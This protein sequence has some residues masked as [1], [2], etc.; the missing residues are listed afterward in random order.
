MKKLL[1]ILFSLF[2]LFHEL[3][4]SLPA[5]AKQDAKQLAQPQAQSQPA[6]K[7]GNAQLAKIKLGLAISQ[8]NLDQIQEIE[9]TFPVVLSQPL[10]NN[11]IPV[12]MLIDEILEGYDVLDDEVLNKKIDIYKFFLEKKIYPTKEKL[13]K[14]LDTLYDTKN[15][16]HVVIFYEN[17][18]LNEAMEVEAIPV[19]QDMVDLGFVFIN[20][21]I[22]QSQKLKN[23]YYNNVIESKT[24]QNIIERIYQLNLYFYTI[25]TELQDFLKGKTVRQKLITSLNFFNYLQKEYLAIEATS[26]NNLLNNYFMIVGE[27]RTYV[28]N[29]GTLLFTFKNV[30]IVLLKDGLKILIDQ[31]YNINSLSFSGYHFVI[32]MFNTFTKDVN[33]IITKLNIMLENNFNPDYSDGYQN[34]LLYFILS[35]FKHGHLQKEDILQI[36]NILFSPNSTHKPYSDINQYILI[37]N[38]HVTLLSEAMSENLDTE[39]IQFLLNKGAD[40][41]QIIILGGNNVSNSM[42]IFF[43]D[44]IIPY[45][46]IIMNWF[47]KNGKLNRKYEIITEN[48]G[49]YFKVNLTWLQY[50]IGQKN[51]F[52]D[53]S[54]NPA[55]SKRSI[56]DIFLEKYGQKFNKFDNYETFDLNIN[57]ILNV[58]L[59]ATL[60]ELLQLYKGD[61]NRLKELCKILHKYDLLAFDQSIAQNLLD[62]NVPKFFEKMKNILNTFP[63]SVQDKAYI[64]QSIDHYKKYIEGTK[65]LVTTEAET[66]AKLEQEQQHSMEQKEKEFED[67]LER[68]AK[69][70]E[71]AAYRL[72]KLEKSAEPSKQRIA[73]EEFQKLSQLYQSFEAKKHNIEAKLQPKIIQIVSTTSSSAAQLVQPKSL[74]DKIM[75]QHQA[76]EGATPNDVIDE[77]NK[78]IKMSHQIINPALRFQAG[79]PRNL[80]DRQIAIQ[81]DHI[82]NIQPE[83]GTNRKIEFSGGHLYDTLNSFMFTGIID[84]GK[85]F[86]DQN[87][88]C[89]VFT[90]NNLIT[91][92]RMRKTTFPQ[93]WS[94]YDIYQAIISSKKIKEEQSDTALIITAQVDHI[95]SKFNI[96]MILYKIPQTDI[97]QIVTAYPEISENLVTTTPSQAAASSSRSASRAS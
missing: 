34:N 54:P 3:K 22:S 8:N 94:V 50:Q 38:S 17:F 63:I 77:L 83:V 68:L 46:N 43:G 19:V 91:Q 45:F 67:A 60:P 13:Q 23:L 7:S 69:A 73:E 40:P 14:I 39:I 57:K 92:Q 16:K 29:L 44:M 78:K 72:Q 33:S 49:L 2:Q 53:A 9:Q 65:A 75:M 37:Y 87:S 41:S 82:I 52:L 27:E 31:G 26:P 80:F 35:A 5:K 28:T 74:F 47:D 30:S 56:L 90:G 64:K 18:L 1:L 58:S 93:N 24:A 61:P 15:D 48:P 42:P 59:I 4:P 70:K 71:L 84:N 51:A 76:P 36:F 10:V 32:Q 55:D 88:G 25:V 66:R 21:N 95:G 85:Y 97:W 62:I 86:K 12:D 6:A 81:L 96:R 89:W 79:K 11:K 20:L